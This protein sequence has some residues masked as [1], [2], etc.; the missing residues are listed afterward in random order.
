MHEIGVTEK[1]LPNDRVNSNFRHRLAI[2]STETLTLILPSNY[3]ILCAMR[4]KQRIAAPSSNRSPQF[5]E[6]QHSPG[7]F[8]VIDPVYYA[9]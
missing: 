4:K 2:G 1:I 5:K 8:V 9:D 3:L 7:L 6:I